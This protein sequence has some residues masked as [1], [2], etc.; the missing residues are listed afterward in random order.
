MDSVQEGPA[1]RRYEKYCV[2]GMER[3]GH[4]TVTCHGARCSGASL[5]TAVAPCPPA[6]QATLLVGLLMGPG[7]PTGECTLGARREPC[8]QLLE[9]GWGK[10]IVICRGDNL[11]HIVGS[12]HADG[13]IRSKVDQ[14]LL[15]LRTEESHAN[16]VFGVEPFLDTFVAIQTP[17]ILEGNVPEEP[18][19]L[20]GSLWDDRGDTAGVDAET[21]SLADLRRRPRTPVD[22]ASPSGMYPYWNRR[23]NSTCSG[24]LP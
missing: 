22:T 6:T 24:L 5:S 17:N 3:D 2:D 23:Q 19:D 10:S 11:L 16:V 12:G 14:R 4:K 21:Y 13:L 15:V 20:L 18:I 1:T 7:A 9:I 8:G